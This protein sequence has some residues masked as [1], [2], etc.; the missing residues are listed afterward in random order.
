MSHNF[1]SNYAYVLLTYLL[2]LFYTQFPA[3]IADLIV[4]NWSQVEIIM[5][6]YFLFRRE[7]QRSPNKVLVSLLIDVGLPLWPQSYVMFSDDMGQDSKP[8]LRLT[9]NRNCRNNTYK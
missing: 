9:L 4:Q 2:S 3:Y 6:I 1:L 7:T 5:Y 8:K